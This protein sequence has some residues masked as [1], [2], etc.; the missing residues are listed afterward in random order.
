MFIVQVRGHRY[1]PFMSHWQ[2]LGVAHLHITDANRVQRNVAQAYKETRVV[3]V[4]SN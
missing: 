3:Y 4:A 1:D 2:T